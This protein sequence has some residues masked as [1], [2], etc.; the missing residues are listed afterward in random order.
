PC[1]RTAI[2][3]A[4]KKGASWCLLYNGSSLRLV[5]AQRLHSRRYVEFELDAALDETR[6]FAVL[7][8]TL[9]ARM[10][11][12]GGSGKSP[13]Q[14]LI[15]ESERHGSAVCRSLRDGVLRA[16]AEVLRAMLERNVP[17]GA[18]MFSEKPTR[19]DESFEQALTIVYRILFLLFAE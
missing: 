7:V 1:W 9:H 13:L 11:S 12:P 6:T 14:I 16:S 10:L 8:S 18:N 17:P 3:H 15:E 5:D 19:L 4:T 2:V